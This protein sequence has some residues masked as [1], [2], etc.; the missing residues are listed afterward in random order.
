MSL[1]VIRHWVDTAPRVAYSSHFPGPPKTTQQIH[2]MF[3]LLSLHSLSSFSLSY[4]PYSVFWEYSIKGWLSARSSPPQHLLSTHSLSALPPCENRRIN[5]VPCMHWYASKPQPRNEPEANALILIL[6]DVS[7]LT[8]HQG[9]RRK[10]NRSS[11]TT[12]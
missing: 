3:V 11:F 1:G 5:G 2:I 10:G 7:S 12:I 4:P 6:Y 8:I 9:L